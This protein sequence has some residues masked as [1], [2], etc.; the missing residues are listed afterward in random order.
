MDFR[1]YRALAGDA[2]VFDIVGESTSA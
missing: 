2:N 1:P